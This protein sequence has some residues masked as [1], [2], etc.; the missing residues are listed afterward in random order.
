VGKKNNPVWVVRE[1]RA[2]RPG[3]LYVDVDERPLQR[4]MSPAAPVTFVKR[5]SA[6]K[7]ASRKRSNYDGTIF[8]VGRITERRRRVV[9]LQVN[10]DE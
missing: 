10:P 2:W 4:S 1:Y 9:E 5:S 8:L 3:W 7:Y 6:L